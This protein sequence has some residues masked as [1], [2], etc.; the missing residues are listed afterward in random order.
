MNK[1]NQDYLDG[2]IMNHWSFSRS[3]RFND[4]KRCFFNSLNETK[5]NNSN[6]AN[7]NFINGGTYIGQC[8]HET[9]KIVLQEQITQFGNKVSDMRMYSVN[10]MLDHFEDTSELILSKSRQDR[11]FEKEKNRL[12]K[13]ARDHLKTWNTNFR[14]MYRGHEII[15]FEEEQMWEYEGNEIQ[16]IVDLVTVKDNAMC[17]TDW[18]TNR[19]PK[20][21]NNNA[22]LTSYIIWAEENYSQYEEFNS[23]FFYTKTG[24][25][26]ENA[27]TEMK[28]YSM[29]S[30]IS[31][32][33]EIWRLKKIDDF[34]RNT[35]CERCN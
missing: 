27:I 7:T 15:S 31:E 4:C 18:K 32:E 13:T 35:N 14:N 33:A 30:Q 2:E 9:I 16:L 20:P 6:K 12:D 29:K 10:K 24:K 34:P 26:V 21:R 11:S 25:K 3:Q 22:Q 1:L 17:I 28:K 19:T 8:V 5:S 23:Y